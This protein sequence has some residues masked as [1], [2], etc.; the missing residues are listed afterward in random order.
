[1]YEAIRS[2]GFQD[3]KVNFSFCS[4]SSLEVKLSMRYNIGLMR[5]FIEK[6]FGLFRY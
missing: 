4:S 5:V 2:S 1:M 3:V 6:D